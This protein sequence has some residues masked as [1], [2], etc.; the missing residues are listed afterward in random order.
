VTK[1]G[2]TNNGKKGGYFEGRPQSQGGIKAL[3]TDTNRP[4]EVEGGEVVITKRAVADNSKKEFEGQML[5]NKQILSKI[6]QSGGGVELAKGGEIETK[7]EEGGE[8]TDDDWDFE[9]DHTIFADGGVILN[10][11]EEKILR[12][13]K[14]VNLTDDSITYDALKYVFVEK[15]TPN[16]Y[17]ESDFINALQTLFINNFID[18]GVNNSFSISDKGKDYLANMTS[19]STS[20]QAIAELSD[21]E[22]QILELIKVKTDQSE[23][24]YLS[25]LENALVQKKTVL[26]DAFTKADLKTALKKLYGGNSKGAYYIGQTKVFEDSTKK[27]VYSISTEG[28]DYLKRTGG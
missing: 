1:K 8:L 9:L 24:A 27:Q 19:S 5:T 25:D 15:K 13:I 10:D 18:D 3:N 14:N 7:F 11:L 4:I 28:I 22:V 23:W 26:L 2:T 6:N 20:P 21:K 16:P 17:T 12:L